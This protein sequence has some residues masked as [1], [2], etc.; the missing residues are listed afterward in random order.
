MN[1]QHLRYM[2][3]VERVGSITKAA[4]N[5]FMGQPNLSKAI[6]EVENEIGVTVFKRSAKGVIPT[7]KGEEF[8][9]YAK[10]ILLQMQKIEELYMPETTDTAVLKIS[11]PRTAYITG[12]FAEIADRIPQEK[13]LKAELHETNSVETI[14]SI[15]ESSCTIGLIRYDTEDKE[16]FMSYIREKNLH[17]EVLFR[18]RSRILLSENDAL[19][20][21]ETVS[22]SE[23]SGYTEIAYGD[24][25]VPYLSSDYVRRTDN[26]LTNR[27]IFV[28]DRS[29]LMYGLR[30]IKNSFAADEPVS[31]EIL[32]RTGLKQLECSDIPRIYEDMLIL[33]P[34]ARLSDLENSFIGHLKDTVS[35][36]S[37]KERINK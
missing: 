11:A 23:L 37:E 35:A 8:L 30:T 2:V 19:A 20:E 12:V 4:S 6:K 24:N 16:Y 5:L 36:L 18:F 26:E 15:L 3:E 29:S 34:S 17:C 33:S 1:L 14:R 9:L 25:E 28:Y 7:H 22:F 31:K 13:R 32:E 27:K 21:R 10:N